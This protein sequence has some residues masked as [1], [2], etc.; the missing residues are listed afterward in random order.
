L[1]QARDEKATL[2]ENGEKTMAKLKKLADAFHQLQKEKSTLESS[3]A[4]QKQALEQAIT[5]VTTLESSQKDQV[6]IKSLPSSG[7]KVDLSYASLEDQN[8]ALK[9]QLAERTASATEMTQR[10]QGILGQLKGTRDAQT[11]SEQEVQRLKAEMESLKKQSASQ[12]SSLK[13]ELQEALSECERLGQ[14]LDEQAR[15]SEE[16]Q[17]ALGLK[18]QKLN[19]E[20][21]R[22]ES[23]VAKAEKEKEEMVQRVRKA[24]QAFQQAQ[25][26]KST[27]E[28]ELRN[29]KEAY[30]SVSKERDS[31]MEK[32]DSVQGME[33]AY[34]ALSMERDSLLEK[35]DKLAE[36]VQSQSKGQED[37]DLKEAYRAVSMERDSLLEKLEKLT[38]ALQSQSKGQEDQEMKEAYRVVSMER[39]TLLE[40][41]ESQGQDDQDLKEAYRAVSMERDSL[42]EKLE[43]IT[44]E[45]EK[46]VR[47]RSGS[48]EELV[49]VSKERD[50]LLR[51]LAELEISYKSVREEMESL[52]VEKVKSQG[53]SQE[54]YEA[55]CLERDSLLKAFKAMETSVKERDVLLIDSQNQCEAIGKERDALLKT[56]KEMESSFKAVS[57]ERDALLWNGSEGSGGEKVQELEKAC[58]ALR[59]ERDSLQTRLD[60]VV[61]ERVGLAEMLAQCQVLLQES[62]RGRE[63]SEKGFREYQALLEESRRGREEVERGYRE[64]V[65]SLELEKEALIKTWEERLEQ[66]REGTIKAHE[67]S[68]GKGR[69]VHEMLEGER[70][71]NRELSEEVQRLNEVVEVHAATSE[72][73]Q[74]ALGMQIKKL[75]AANQELEA[76]LRATATVSSPKSPSANQGELQMADRDRLS[77]ENAELEQKLKEEKVRADA[78]AD[79]VEKLKE[80][81]KKLMAA[82]QALKDKQPSSAPSSPSHAD[83]SL[84]QEEKRQ[85]EKRISSLVEESDRNRSALE[86]LTEQYAILQQE[87]NELLS[88]VDALKRNKADEGKSPKSNNNN[89]NNN[90][91]HSAEELSRLAITLTAKEDDVSRL[92]LVNIQLE[93]DLSDTKELVSRF[94]DDLETREGE[95]TSLKDAL[96][97]QQEVIGLL[98][99]EVGSANAELVSSRD[100]SCRVEADLAAQSEL[101]ESLKEQ[102]IKQREAF[103]AQMERAMSGQD[104]GMELELAQREI[105][106]LQEEDIPRLTRYI[107]EANKEVATCQKEIGRL[108]SE[109][110]STTAELT[111]SRE[112]TGVLQEASLRLRETYQAEIDRAT[113]ALTNVQAEFTSAKAEVQRLQRGLVLQEEENGKAFAQMQEELE[114]AQ[115]ELDRV[116]EVGTGIEDKAK[117]EVSRL[118]EVMAGLEE[119]YKEQVA[120][121]EGELKVLKGEMQALNEGHRQALAMK[122][123][124]REAALKKAEEHVLRA[125]DEVVL[126]QSQHSFEVET[127]RNQC[128]ESQNE[129][130]RLRTLCEES[131][132]EGERLQT[133]YDES[134]SEVERLRKQFDERQ[135]EVESLRIK[136]DESLSEVEVLRNRFDESLDEAESVRKDKAALEAQ[137]Q[138]MT[139]QLT[140]A[141][142]VVSR[143][144]KAGTE[145]GALREQVAALSVDKSKLE[146]RMRLV[147]TESEESIQDLANQL[148][149]AKDESD[150]QRKLITVLEARDRSSAAVA[151]DSR[152]LKE[153]LHELRKEYESRLRT[154]E[155][156]LRNAKSLSTDESSDGWEKVSSWD[157]SSSSSSDPF[158]ALLHY[159]RSLEHHHQSQGPSTLLLQQKITSLEALIMELNKEKTQLE[160]LSNDLKR[161]K[162]QLEESVQKAKS[163]LGVAKTK[164]HERVQELERVREDLQMQVGEGRK[165]LDKMNMEAIRVDAERVAEKE[166]LEGEIDRLR[167]ELDTAT[168]TIAELNNSSAD[169]KERLHRNSL[170]VSELAMKLMQKTQLLQVATQEKDA[171]EQGLAMERE[172]MKA[173]VKEE[174]AKAVSEAQERLAFQTMEVE[175]HA[176]DYK[177]LQATVERQNNAMAELAEERLKMAVELQSRA[178]QVGSLMREREALLVDLERRTKDFELL[179]TRQ[180]DQRATLKTASF[181]LQQLR[182]EKAAAEASSK[183]QSERANA[184]AGELKELKRKVAR[185]EQAASLPQSPSSVSLESIDGGASFNATPP[186]PV[187]QLDELSRGASFGR[188]RGKSIT[189]GGGD[190]V[191]AQ[192]ALSPR[193]WGGSEASDLL[194]SMSSQEQGFRLGE[195]ST[196]V[197][198]QSGKITELEGKLDQKS[199]DNEKAKADL[200][201]LNEKLE[202]T[203]KKVQQLTAENRDLLA[204]LMTAG[205]NTIMDTGL[206]P[207]VGG[208]PHLLGRSG[209]NPMMTSPDETSPT[210]P[211]SKKLHTG[212]DADDRT[213]LDPRILDAKL[214]TVSAELE[215]TKQAYQQSKDDLAALTAQRDILQDIIDKGGGGRLGSMS[216]FQIVAPY[217]HDTEKGEIAGLSISAMRPMTSLLPLGVMGGSDSKLAHRLTRGARSLD[218][219]CLHTAAFLRNGPGA[220]FGTII[221]L[222]LLHLYF[223]HILIVGRC[224]I[225]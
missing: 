180:K 189:E 4:A 83:R 219:M 30:T 91:S 168:A 147:A 29:V 11:A 138:A 154:V 190:E 166:S 2:A 218:A 167:Q 143:F 92:Q 58:L 113:G 78:Q 159:I 23:E 178:E 102:L 173:R 199:K 196:K 129:A 41:L 26:D 207:F 48:S 193:G 97:A 158:D 50:K 27:A 115:A 99:T 106:R 31:L 204:K 75:M 63:E 179:T 90:N 174:L 120:R 112:E 145:L 100:Q 125:K 66:E 194:D 72:E 225:S 165:L 55:L 161:E 152:V 67:E 8:R 162:T 201:T 19:K 206:E 73:E 122:D 184:L 211:L 25:R 96:S 197:E 177:A 130:E 175:K 222:F 198:T 156:V 43:K 15:I 202:R 61:K 170:N 110:E 176:S 49:I 155:D 76:R 13:K 126:L 208:G 144:Q 103:S 51:S 220:R 1:I 65:S 205:K 38:E 224:R 181:Q 81:L 188:R 79:A 74:A 87:N 24:A 17:T 131:Q 69:A 86:R 104:R 139:S 118:K 44:E 54:Q 93:K 214:R 40:K 35:L 121:A 98:Q 135:N 21:E 111:K 57:E 5:R 116:G 109:L 94:K 107:S 151:E 14:T 153:Q 186:P 46:D 59:E 123:E 140:G 89:N 77:K 62:R 60:E 187:P 213:T 39:D 52:L 47:S 18:T 221:Y 70:R 148:Q 82:Y 53:A 37:Q 133:M 150:E 216:A 101:V 163:D 183:L 84:P 192:Q 95:L 200:A 134:Q 141:K 68:T 3:A 185:L 117:E 215:S 22:L 203:S 71:R 16:E 114:R 160:T 210:N 169:L 80:K 108:T 127:L 7:S 56:F 20:K 171:A 164:A 212:A 132:S 124:E 128:D 32:L 142:E 10:V 28:D 191:V 36:A 6:P 12:V 88:Q 172:N 42:L 45:Y 33:E 209:N 119:S 217:E 157:D 195:L 136:L 85:L 105:S 137:L 223:M 64:R 9:Q 146:E 34:R 149:A 182:E